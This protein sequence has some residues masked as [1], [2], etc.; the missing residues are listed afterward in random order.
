MKFSLWK[1]GVG[2][3]RSNSAS[4]GSLLESKCLNIYLSVKGV[5]FTM[6]RIRSFN[7]QTNFIQYCFVCFGT[8]VLV[9][10]YTLNVRSHA[11]RN[12]ARTI[13]HLTLDTH[14]IYSRNWSLYIQN[15]TIH[16][17]NSHHCNAVI[18][19]WTAY[20]DRRLPD[21][22]RYIIRNPLLTFKPVFIHCACDQFFVL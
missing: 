5:N 13:M 22:Q 8:N 1:L 7:I 18:L 15:K 14:R 3:N 4:I 6:D 11:T 9:T 12:E 17:K 20:E 2:M 16:W 21:C 19:F 10:K